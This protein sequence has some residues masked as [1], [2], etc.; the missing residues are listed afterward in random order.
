MSI[1]VQVGSGKK[2]HSDQ[3]VFDCGSG[4]SANYNAMGIG[5]GQMNKIFISHL[6][7]DHMSDLS[8]MYQG[9]PQATARRRCSSLARALRLYLAGP[10][11]G[12][13][14]VSVRSLRRWHEDVLRDVAGDA[15]MAVRRVLLPEH[16]RELCTR[17]RR[18]KRCGDCRSRMA[19][20][21]NRSE[22]REPSGSPGIARTATSIHSPT[23]TPWFPSSCSTT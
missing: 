3:A 11:P 1:F 5:W 13:S 9:G 8:Y 12:A 6:H 16:G 18:S 2:G 22:T 17:R 10:G 14:H 23:A 4:V 19:S 15:A 7:G 21:R 20:T